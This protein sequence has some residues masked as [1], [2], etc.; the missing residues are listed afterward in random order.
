MCETCGFNKMGPLPAQLAVAWKCPAD[1]VCDGRVITR[2]WDVSRTPQFSYL[3]AQDFCLWG[4][5]KEKIYCHT[6]Q[7]ITEMKNQDS[8]GGLQHH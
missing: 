7:D 4:Y 3:T 1:Y 8:H 6:F 5:I 2:F